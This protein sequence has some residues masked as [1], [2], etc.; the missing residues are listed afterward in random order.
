MHLYLNG[1]R[2]Y[3]MQSLFEKS[4]NSNTPVSRNTLLDSLDI[5]NF[6]LLL[7]NTGKFPSFS[8]FKPIFSFSNWLLQNLL[9]KSFWLHF[10][11][12]FLAWFLSHTIIKLDFLRDF[13]STD[14]LWVTV[15]FYYLF[16]IW[17]FEFKMA[18]K[19]QQ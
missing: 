3:G 13:F 9:H 2:K 7:E 16:T 1:L 19:Q 6:H 18:V 14:Y 8:L 12:V 15:T 4:R 5:V 11:S 10:G 17:I